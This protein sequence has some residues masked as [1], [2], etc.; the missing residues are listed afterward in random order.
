MKHADTSSFVRA[1]DREHIWS[2]FG[3]PVAVSAYCHRWSYFLHTD[4]SFI[5][6]LFIYYVFIH[7]YIHTFIHSFSHSVVH[8]FIHSVISPV[9]LNS[10]R[11]LVHGTSTKS[12]IWPN[13]P[14]FITHS[15]P[16]NKWLNMTFFSSRTPELFYSEMN[17][18][19]KIKAGPDFSFTTSCSTSFSV[20]LRLW[21][22]E[23]ELFLT[24]IAS[25]KEQ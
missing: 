8:S 13:V 1:R 25:L 11:G 4:F 17:Q 24:K 15:K 14:T 3:L 7:S 20:G 21:A 9:S 10:R 19:N 2:A 16:L 6:Y 22:A 12:Y 5:Y 23:T 18:T